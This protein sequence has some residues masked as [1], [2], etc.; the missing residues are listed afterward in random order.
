M[1]VRRGTGKR[2]YAAVT[3]LVSWALDDR[4]WPYFDGWCV[5]H[6]VDHE[7]LRWD[8]WLNLVYYFAVRNMSTEERK[9]FEDEIANVVAAAHLAK[10]KPLLD[11]ARNATAS[12]TAESTRPGRRMPPKPAGWGDDKRA[13]FDNKAAIKTLTAG[14]VSGKSRRK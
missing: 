6:G 8:R 11:G 12:A 4:V 7:S 2:D 14:G 13:T 10:A 1:A 9:T 5:A 3:Y